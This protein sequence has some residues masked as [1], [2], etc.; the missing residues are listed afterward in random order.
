MTWLIV[1]FHRDSYHHYYMTRE[2]F[3]INNVIQHSKLKSYHHLYQNFRLSGRTTRKKITENNKAK[4]N[5][6]INMT[7]QGKFWRVLKTVYEKLYLKELPRRVMLNRAP[8]PP[9]HFHL[10]LTLSDSFSAHSH[11]L[12]LISGPH[13]KQYFVAYCLLTQNCMKFMSN[14]NKLHFLF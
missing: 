8:T 13:D 10:F 2:Y 6:E 3:S 5:T 7:K 14:L 12:R 11:Q 4:W 1:L 9:T